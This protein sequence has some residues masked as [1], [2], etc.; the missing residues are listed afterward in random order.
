MCVRFHVPF[1][2]RKYDCRTFEICVQTELRV[3]GHTQA[4]SGSPDV[5]GQIFKIFSKL[6]TWR[7]LKELRSEISEMKEVCD[8]QHLTSDSDNICVTAI[9]ATYSC[10]SFT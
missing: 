8:I 7:R 4:L 5:E 6:K 10:V 9:S 3:K 1:N 2:W